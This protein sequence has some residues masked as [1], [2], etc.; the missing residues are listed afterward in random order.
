MPDVYKAQE[1][2]RKKS[3]PKKKTLKSESV[4]E[5]SVH[6]HFMHPLS[7]YCYFPKNVHFVTQDSDEK[8]VLLLRQHP[9]INTGWIL[10]AILGLFAPRLLSTFPLLEFLPANFQTVT[11]LGW[12]LLA[13]AFIFEKFLSWFF[14]VFLIT[15]ERVIDVDFINLIYREIAA[16][17]IDKIQDVTVQSGGVAMSLFNYGNVIIQTAAEQPLIQFEKVPRP[18]RVARI[19]RKLIIEEEQEKIEGRVR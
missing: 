17:N 13:T 7:S 4:V 5:P 3:R 10:L 11:I 8:V 15:D 2:S 18:D 16:A 6:S 12:Y 14:S 19:L 9:I 1:N